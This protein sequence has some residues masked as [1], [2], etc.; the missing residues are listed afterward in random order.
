MRTH[1]CGLTLG[2]FVYVLVLVCP[3]S[4]QPILPG[5]ELLTIPRVSGGLLVNTRSGS[6]GAT[7]LMRRS[8]GEVRLYF[9]QLRLLGAFQHDDDRRLELLFAASVGRSTVQARGVAT[10]EP[11]RYREVPLRE[12][13]Q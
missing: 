7:A 4:A 8:L 10:T 2:V 5:D 1:A 12:L 13:V 3:A 9:G 6:G 11:G